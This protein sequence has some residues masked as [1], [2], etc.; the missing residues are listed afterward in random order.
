MLKVPLLFHIEKRLKINFTYF[1]SQFYTVEILFPSFLLVKY[2]IKYVIWI[3]FKKKKK[4][5]NIC[6]FYEICQWYDE[7]RFYKIN[8]Q[9]KM[10]METNVIKISGI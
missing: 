7:I 2:E 8:K 9:K 10:Y 6:F 1:L 3:L 5:V 4:Y